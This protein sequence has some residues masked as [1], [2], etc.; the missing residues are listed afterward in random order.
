M[1]LTNYKWQL[2]GGGMEFGETPEEALVREFQEELSV[3]P[4]I[5]HPN[6]IVM[7]NTWMGGDD[8]TR[9][10]VHII[11]ICYLLDIKD[12]QPIITDPDEETGDF[13][14]FSYEQI[15]KLDCLPKT[16]QYIKRAK[17]IVQNYL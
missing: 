9:D 13:G 11:L 3:T 8:D 12:Q 15:M 7:T 5:I 14:W 2:A 16:K 17:Y 6:A 10:D 4:T 1:P